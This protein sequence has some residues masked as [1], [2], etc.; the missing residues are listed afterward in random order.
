MS[1]GADSAAAS[2][3][4]D[5][6]RRPGL[7]LLLLAANLLITAALGLIFSRL[8][9]PALDGHPPPDLLAWAALYR[10]QPALLWRLAA[11]MGSAALVYTL[12]SAPLSG[13]AL[14]GLAGRGCARGALRH[15]WPLLAM[16]L[17]GQLTAAALL[18]LWGVGAWWTYQL[19]L[20]LVDDRAPAL[21][22]ALLALPWAAL[23]LGVALLHHFGQCLCVE[24]ALG[25][26]RALAAAARLLRR[27]LV[28]CAL[29]WFAGWLVW[30]LITL[31]TGRLPV[32]HP[33]LAQL[34]VA[35][36]VA[37]HLWMLAA[38]RRLVVGAG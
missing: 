31:A 28:P 6:A 27:R 35:L 1:L 32:D 4:R 34:G 17:A 5:V 37:V 29:I 19:P 12:A 25:P 9:G 8:L 24:R 38:A 30:L 2:G 21:A 18:A 16:R 22:Q 23:L 3:A 11:A 7:L 20:P 26:L 15:L 14:S 33:L 10:E 13:A 36:R